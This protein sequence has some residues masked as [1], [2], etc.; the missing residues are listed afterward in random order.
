M[1]TPANTRAHLNAEL[2]RLIGTHRPG[3]ISQ[4][5]SVCCAARCHTKTEQAL[6][7]PQFIV[8][9][10]RAGWK[11]LSESGSSRWFCPSCSRE[12]APKPLMPRSRP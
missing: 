7:R 12:R 11:L 6:D 3:E 5:H 2:E 1:S 9:L 8:F 4:L 10:R